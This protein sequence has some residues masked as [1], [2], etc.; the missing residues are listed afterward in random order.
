MDL[1]TKHVGRT[2]AMRHTDAS[3]SQLIQLVMILIP[4]S[5]KLTTIKQMQE[6]PDTLIHIEDD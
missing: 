5:R 2:F 6:H 1:N 3:M 4:L